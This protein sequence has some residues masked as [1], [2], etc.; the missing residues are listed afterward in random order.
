MAHDV[1]FSIPERTLG[2]SDIE[3]KVLKNS[4]TLGMLKISKGSVVWF[5]KDTNRGKK[6][7][8][9]DFDKMMQEHAKL[10]E[11]R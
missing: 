10:T 7:L 3:F 4:S 11:N 1:K 2:R 5:P 8:W 6:M 9:G